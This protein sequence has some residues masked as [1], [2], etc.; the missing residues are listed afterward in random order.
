MSNL[1]N[2]ALKDQIYEDMREYFPNNLELAEQLTNIDFNDRCNG[3]TGAGMSGQFSVVWLCSECDG[4]GVVDHYT[5]YG[6]E[7]EDCSHCFNSDGFED[8]K[9]IQVESLF[10]LEQQLD[11]LGINSR[12]FYSINRVLD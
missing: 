6:P 4:R 12:N 5:G 11:Q 1:Q 7:Q 3:K 10:D 9:H 8:I 2:D